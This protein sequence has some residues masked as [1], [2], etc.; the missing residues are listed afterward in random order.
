MLLLIYTPI[1]LLPSDDTRPVH[2]ISKGGGGGGGGGGLYFNWVVYF[3]VNR[4]KAIFQ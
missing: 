4:I 3:H 1:L 2:R